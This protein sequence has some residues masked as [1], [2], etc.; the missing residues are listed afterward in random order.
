MLGARGTEDSCR[1]P[2]MPRASRNAP[3]TGPRLLDRL[4]HSLMYE[5]TGTSH[6]EKN[7][8]PSAIRGG[9]RII[10]GSKENS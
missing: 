8:P 2:G 1:A 3:A 9:C 6:T 7:C 10:V 4:G 5:E